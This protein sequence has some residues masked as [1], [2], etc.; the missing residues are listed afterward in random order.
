MAAHAKRFVPDAAL[1]AVNTCTQ[2]MGGMGLLR[3]YGLDR[4]S[5]LAQMLKIVD[6]TTEIQR[7]RHRPRPK[8]AGGH[9]TRTTHPRPRQITTPPSPSVGFLLK[10]VIMSGG[11][12]NKGK[13]KMSSSLGQII[14]GIFPAFR[15]TS[16]SQRNH[17]HNS[18]PR[19]SA[20]STGRLPLE[21]IRPRPRRPRHRSG[22]LSLPAQFQP[23]MA[24][25]DHP[26]RRFRPTRTNAMDWPRR[27]PLRMANNRRKPVRN[28]QHTAT[29]HRRRR[30]RPPLRNRHATKRQLP[31]RLRRRRRP[32][33]RRPPHLTPL[34]HHRRPHR[35]RPH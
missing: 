28:R 3:P 31:L 20:I 30:W 8:K 24:G 17:S 27:P 26:R 32:R 21:K 1:R 6:G 34:L 22:I 13:Y 4:L 12:F 18:R 11:L 5:R 19:L 23:R 16:R 9:P 33:K 10:K 29:D 14:S 7:R 15:L 25:I 35:R 2:A